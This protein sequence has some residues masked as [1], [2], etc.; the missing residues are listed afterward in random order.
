MTLTEW[1]QK[2]IY[3]DTDSILQIPTTGEWSDYASN[4]GSGKLQT[5]LWYAAIS[6]WEGNAHYR[7]P[8]LPKI[9]IELIMMNQALLIP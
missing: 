7:Y 8:N 6:D 4:W 2:S 5:K 1:S 3:H 9:E